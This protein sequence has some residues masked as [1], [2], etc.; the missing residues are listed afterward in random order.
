MEFVMI[1]ITKDVFE[2]IISADEPTLVM[3]Y[4]DGC[5]PCGLMKNHLES[6]EIDHLDFMFCRMP[7]SQADDFIPG[8]PTT[9]AYKAGRK[10]GMLVGLKDKAAII[11]FLEE[12]RA[13]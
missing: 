4:A 12:M 11:K 7:A 9:V 10:V 1:E 3:F 2:E 6:I 8:T 13:A 5:K